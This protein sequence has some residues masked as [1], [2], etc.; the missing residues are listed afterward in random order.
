MGKNIRYFI[1][2][3]F[4][5]INCFAGIPFRVY[6]LDGS[7]SLNWT[8]NIVIT[9]TS[10]PFTFLITKSSPNI[11][12]LRA[13]YGDGSISNYIDSG[14]AYHYYNTT[15]QKIIRLKGTLD[16]GSIRFGNTWKTDINPNELTNLAWS[17]ETIRSINILNGITGINSAESMFS[18]ATVFPDISTLT[19]VTLL[20]NTWQK[21][22][23]AVSLPSVSTLTNVTTMN[24]TWANCRNISFPD[25]N[26]L[27]KCTSLIGT[28]S[29]CSYSAS[30]PIITAL[31]NVTTLQNTWANCT[32]LITPPS[33]STLTNITTVQGAWINC[34]NM[35]TFP[36]IFSDSDKLTNVRYAFQKCTNIVGAAP[37][38]WNT[39][40]FPNITLYS[41]CFYG[42]DPLK[43]SN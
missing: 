17:V 38:L 34:T 14:Y 26:N 19:N 12:N 13:D 15:G 1:F 18:T 3:I 2:S 33:I 5:S 42:L 24:Y 21:C 32:N 6:P 28:W 41:G 37:E 22:T 31:T 43:V 40:N 39:V 16:Q 35:T 7:S 36:I 8:L 9:D 11:V 23:N 10:R 29:N 30:M 20:D 25:V 27:S 4:L